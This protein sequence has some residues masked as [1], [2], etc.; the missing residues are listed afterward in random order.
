VLVNIKEIKI[1]VCDKVPKTRDC[2]S[3][4]NKD[5]ACFYYLFLSSKGGYISIAI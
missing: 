3:S 5:L 1:N 4:R 2:L